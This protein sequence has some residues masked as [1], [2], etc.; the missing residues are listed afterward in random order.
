M[1]ANIV[2]FYVEDLGVERGMHP[3]NIITPSWNLCSAC[4]SKCGEPEVRR[5]G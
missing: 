4:I 3:S 5:R 2:V 1:I